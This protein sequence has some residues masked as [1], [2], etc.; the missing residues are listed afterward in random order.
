M[1][2]LEVGGLVIGSFQNT[3]LEYANPFYFGPVADPFHDI[4]L[5]PTHPAHK[6]ALRKLAYKT[7]AQ[8]HQSV[9][10]YVQDGDPPTPTEPPQYKIGLLVE[11]EII[12]K[13]LEKLEND[14]TPGWTSLPPFWITKRAF[15]QFITGGLDYIKPP[16]NTDDV[17]YNALL[18][19]MDDSKLPLTKDKD[20][21]LEMYKKVLGILKNLR[22][23]LCP[24]PKELPPDLLLELQSLV[25]GV[26][27]N[28]GVTKWVRYVKNRTI[29]QSTPFY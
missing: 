25:Q 17:A 28:W 21:T 22:S 24:P 3:K 13:D 1:G 12:C 23:V 16:S 29:V 27:E 5:D 26:P 14:L 18:K 10:I 15:P 20:G 2:L 7:L 6:D 19:A 11:W 8:I 9:P 4:L